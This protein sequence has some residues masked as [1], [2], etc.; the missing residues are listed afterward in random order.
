MISKAGSDRSYLSLQGAYS[1]GVALVTAR[2]ESNKVVF[3]RVLI[4]IAASPASRQR[5]SR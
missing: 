5:S 3:A 1:D 4:E 2:G